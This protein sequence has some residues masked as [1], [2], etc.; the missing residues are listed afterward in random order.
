[1]PTGE[2]RCLSTGSTETY[3]GESV[4]ADQLLNLAETYRRAAR[5]LLAQMERG[6]PVSQAPFRL[7][8]IHAIELYLNALLRHGGLEASRIRSLQ[9]RLRERG[10]LAIGYR[11]QLRNRT[12]AHLAAIDAAREYLGARYDPHMGASASQ[13]N[14]LTATLEEIARKVVRIIG[15]AA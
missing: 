4:T 3:P 1:M 2:P 8:A 7:A 10:E 5:L 12:A 9:H 6:A 13:L 11:L 14:R 15:P